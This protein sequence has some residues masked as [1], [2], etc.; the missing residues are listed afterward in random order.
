MTTTN[1]NPSTAPVGGALPGSPLAVAGAPLDPDAANRHDGF[2][3]LR[4]AYSPETTE[5]A[6][7][8][9]DDL[10]ANLVRA[11]RRRTVNDALERLDDRLRA[12]GG[13]W[14]TICAPSR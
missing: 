9:V 10:L 6:A 11:H 12:R 2:D 14:H 13:R 1:P 7:K 4:A 5:I 8:G 3:A